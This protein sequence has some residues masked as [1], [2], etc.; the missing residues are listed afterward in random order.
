MKTEDMTTL[1]QAEDEVDAEAEDEERIGEQG[2]CLR[3]HRTRSC[4][5]QGERQRRVDFLQVLSRVRLH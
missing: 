1:T 2:K 5:K 3:K 4:G